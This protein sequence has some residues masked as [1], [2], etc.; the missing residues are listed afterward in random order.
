MTN[1]ILFGDC[2][3]NTKKI[4]LIEKVDED[5]AV[6]EKHLWLRAVSDMGNTRY[7]KYQTEEDR[8]IALTKLMNELQDEYDY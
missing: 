2:Y 3:L 5:N 8:D 1:Y 6:S 4:I 7:V